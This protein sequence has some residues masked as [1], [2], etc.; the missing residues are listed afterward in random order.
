V[1][2]R[3]AWSKKRDSRIRRCPA[4]LARNSARCFPN[5]KAHKG[6]FCDGPVEERRIFQVTNI[7]EVLPCL[8]K[9]HSDPTPNTLITAPCSPGCLL[10]VDYHTSDRNNLPYNTD[11]FHPGLGTTASQN[12]APCPVDAGSGRPSFAPPCWLRFKSSL[13]ERGV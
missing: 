3:A 7:I 11:D 6:A 13:V 5:L 9:L 1:H 2:S 4:S 12:S 10:V 8:F